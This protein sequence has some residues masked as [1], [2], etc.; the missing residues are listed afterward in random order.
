[1]KEETPKKKVATPKEKAE[2]PKK[3]AETPK[4]KAET[5]KKIKGISVK[6]IKNKIRS[7]KAERKAALEAKDKKMATIYRRRIS[8]LKKKTRRAA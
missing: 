2:T 1:K 6:D 4:K 5:P 8:K 3:K 7:F